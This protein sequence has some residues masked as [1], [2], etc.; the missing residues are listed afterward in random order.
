TECVK[1]ALKAHLM[2]GSTTVVPTTLSESCGAILQAI[3][4]V[5]TVI[6]ESEDLPHILGMHLEGPYFSP[7]QAGAQDPRYITPPVP[8]DYKKIIESADGFIVKYI[9]APV[10]PRTIDFC[11]YLKE[12]DIL[13]AAGHTDC[14]YD[15]LKTAHPVL[16]KVAL[17]KCP[18]EKHLPEALPQWTVWCAYA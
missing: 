1:G 2:H 15:D 11:D 13:P 6:F 5:K 14:T 16:L 4:D 8:E 10:L 3:E 7:D 12:N 18:T 9:F 17:R